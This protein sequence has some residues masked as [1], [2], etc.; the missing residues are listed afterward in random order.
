MCRDRAR[1]ARGSAEDIAVRSYCLEALR[2]SQG[3]VSRY[4]RSTDEA[5]VGHHVLTIRWASRGEEHADRLV[6]KSKVPGAVIR[7]RLE[8]VYRRL[9][10]RL[11]DLQRLLSPSILD[12]CHT[13]ELDVYAIDSATLRSVMPL[14]ESLWVDQSSEIYVVVMELLEGARH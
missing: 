5:I 11:A 6:I 7:R 13:R 12:D 14:V 10:P 8:E 2:T 4:E 9:D 3:V 1:A